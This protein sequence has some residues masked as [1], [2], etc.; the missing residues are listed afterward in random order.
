MMMM[1]SH[2]E[3]RRLRGQRGFGLIELM[4]A[5]II[6]LLVITAA[7][8][9]RGLNR[10]TY[11]VTENLSRMQEN[12][13]VAFELMAR[14]VREAAGNPCGRN[15]P[16]ANTVVDGENNF[17][18]RLG[19]GIRGFEGGED[20]TDNNVG[21]RIGGTMAIELSSA[22]ASDNL[23][24]VS[25]N[26]TAATLAVNRS[27]H[28]F[29]VGDVLIVCDYRQVAIFQMTGPSSSSTVQINHDRNVSGNPFPGNCTKGLGVP[30]QCTTNGTP[31]Q[32]GPG[33]TIARLAGVRWYIG[34][35]GRGGRSLYRQFNIA[36][37]QEIVEGVND[38]RLA[39]IQEGSGNYV[40]PAAVTDW[41][42]VTSVRI[43]L[44]VESFENVAE[45][46]QPLRRTVEHYVN[47]RNRV[48]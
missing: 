27:D 37:P 39:F 34:D 19:T 29:G 14:D 7:V 16:V 12:S 28:D 15:L 44:D 38:M 18:T 17:W 10:Q 6:G 8:S 13:R 46:F 35:N 23:T 25:H 5:I 21:N 11:R 1:E 43:E 41:G 40:A 31:Y 24:V 20:F 2:P 42:R 48:P 47:L 36:A 9:G 26:P 22:S 32:Y 45:G 30:V 4:V 3:R 33:S